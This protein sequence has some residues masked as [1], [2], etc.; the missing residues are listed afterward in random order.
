[1]RTTLDLDDDLLSALLD[2]HP[3]LSKTDAIEVAIRTYLSESAV[4][5]LRERA[6]NW[7]IVDISRELRDADRST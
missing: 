6:G 4:R 1:M 5:A 7:D 2:R 3:E